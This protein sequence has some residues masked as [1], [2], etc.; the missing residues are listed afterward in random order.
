MQYLVNFG[1][2]LGLWHG[3]FI[4]YLKN[5]IINLIKRKILAYNERINLRNYFLFLKLFKKIEPFLRIKVRRKNLCL[6]HIEN[7]SE[8]FEL[9]FIHLFVCLS[10]GKF[11]IGWPHWFFMNAGQKISFGPSFEVFLNS[12]QNTLWSPL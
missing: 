5:S 9:L 8:Y 3:L 11:L 1:G 2:L 4:T 10:R 6:A 12:S 7:K